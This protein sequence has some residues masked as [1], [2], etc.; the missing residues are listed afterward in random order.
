[1]FGGFVG[2]CLV[3]IL[4]FA[5]WLQTWETFSSPEAGF[6]IKYP[7]IFGARSDKDETERYGIWGF[8][9]LRIPEDQK[10]PSTVAVQATR[11]R[12]KNRQD[13]NWIEERI[14][15]VYEQ[16]KI[17]Y[18]HGRVLLVDGKI[19]EKNALLIKMED[20]DYTYFVEYNEYFYQIDTYISKK[21]GK[22]EQYF[23]RLIVYF[24]LKSV[25]FL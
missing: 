8:I 11:Y 13:E 12:L 24:M 5:L 10:L 17:I 21:F 4:G 22:L 18:P 3:A 19:G 14:T 1:M 20:L 7:K 15:D 23:Y 6:S 25:H 9:Y 16:T 2:L